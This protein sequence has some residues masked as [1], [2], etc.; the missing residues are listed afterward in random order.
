MKML[1]YCAFSNYHVNPRI[2]FFC[3]SITCYYF[4]IAL[5]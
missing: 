5:G 1:K 2:Y 3:Q 4:D